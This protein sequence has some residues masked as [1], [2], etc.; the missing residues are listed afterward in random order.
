MQKYKKTLFN[1][2]SLLYQYLRL[3]YPKAEK[4]VGK[5]GMLVDWDIEGAR[6]FV[7]HLL[8]DVNDHEM[9]SKI[10]KIFRQDKF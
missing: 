8:E 10:E 3:H 9:M 1:E 4:L 7:L 2:S 5:I 6:S